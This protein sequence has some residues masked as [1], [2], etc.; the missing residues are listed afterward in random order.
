MK[1]YLSLLLLSLTV[2]FSCST[3]PNEIPVSSNVPVPVDVFFVSTKVNGVAMSVS[4]SGEEGYSNFIGYTEKTD[5]NNECINRNYNV[6]LK[7][8]SNT[9]IPEIEIGFINLL[10]E[11][12]MT[13]DE[14]LSYLET[15]I[16]SK[17]YPYAGT[18]FGEGVALKYQASSTSPRY[19]TYNTVQPMTSLFE[20]TAVE[21]VDCSPKKCVI[22]SGTFTATLFNLIDATDTLEFTDGSFKIKI[23]SQN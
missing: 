19:T 13:C 12:T 2:L 20:V 8:L 6:I 21:I 7:S 11:M 14:E 9:I 4:T 16:E 18:A 1:S 10:D 3:D 22:V 17:L 5:V 23:Q 15:L